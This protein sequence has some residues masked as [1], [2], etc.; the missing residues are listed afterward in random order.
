MGC[1]QTAA[2]CD[3]AFCNEFFLYFSQCD[4]K[5]NVT[6]QK[7][8]VLQRECIKTNSLQPTH[9]SILSP[10]SWCAQELLRAGAGAASCRPCLGRLGVL[11]ARAELAELGQFGHED[12]CSGD[13]VP[14]AA[15][16]GSGGWV[17][18]LFWA[19]GVACGRSGLPRAH[20]EPRADANSLDCSSWRRSG[21]F[22]FSSVFVSCCFRVFGTRP[23]VRWQLS[24]LFHF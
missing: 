12:C 9:Q 4:R 1:Q 8:L 24:N 7:A 22:S 6:K 5:Q 20:A 16:G 14:R 23:F 2:F 17:D 13:C 19:A 10:T 18:G 21:G 3:T 15:W 11:V